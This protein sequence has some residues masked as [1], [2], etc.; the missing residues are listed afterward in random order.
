MKINTC[1]K[2]PI[3]GQMVPA[4]EGGGKH[5]SREFAGMKAVDG[6]LMRE[7]ASYCLGALKLCAEIFLKEWEY[8]SALASVPRAGKLLRKT[9]AERLIH[10]TACS[11][12]A[13]PV[14]DELYGYMPAYMR[15]A[16]RNEALGIVSSYRNCA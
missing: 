2:V 3:C 9:A 10:S 1:Y 12:A 5:R 4:A 14:F 16:V 11:K 15:R 6:R 7:T 13:Y 8:L